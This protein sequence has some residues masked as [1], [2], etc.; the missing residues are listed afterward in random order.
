MSN[1]QIRNNH[2]FFRAFIVSIFMGLQIGCIQSETTP[3]GALNSFK[4]QVDLVRGYPNLPFEHYTTETSQGSVIDFYLATPSDPAPLLLVVQGSGCSS[5]IGL[6]NDGTG[7][8]TFL[9]DTIFEKADG[10]FAVL[11]VDKA[12]VQPGFFDQT[13]EMAA[14]SKSFR[15]QHTLEN[16]S[17]TLSLAIDAAKQNEGVLAGA[18]IRIIGFSEG[19]ITAARL[20]AERSDISHVTF[21]SGFGCLLFDDIIVLA[22]RQWLKENPDASTENIQDGVNKTSAV[23]M[24]NFAPAMEANPD[25]EFLIEGQSALFWSSYGIACPASD[26]ASTDAEVFVI[27]GLNDESLIAEGVEE[28]P[29]RRQL[30]GKSTKVIRVSGGN[31]I[32]GR[33][34]D[35]EEIDRLLEVF[36]VALDWM[37]E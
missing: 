11:A 18:P 19:S 13:G 31:H 35:Q 6:E 30:A 36:D 16:W 21:I 10:R 8:T 7:F 14:C 12:G 28:I 3:N 23:V 34:G 4:G 5:V 29:V 9:Q 25:P 33:P 27:V 1:F 24:E 26:L 22:Q 37:S 15:A 2:F 32:L 20:S 17:K